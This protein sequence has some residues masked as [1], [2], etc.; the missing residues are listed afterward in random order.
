[1]WDSI[2]WTPD[3][4][5]AGWPAATALAGGVALFLAGIADFRRSL[6]IGSPVTR[7]TGAAAVLATIPIGATVSAGLHLAAVLGVVVVMLW[8]S[9]SRIA[10]GAATRPARRMSRRSPPR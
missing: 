5:P 10:S 3:P 6:A 7:I 8:V 2:R 1:M 9:V 4:A